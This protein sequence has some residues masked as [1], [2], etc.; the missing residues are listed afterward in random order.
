[1]KILKLNDDLDLE[2]PTELLEIETF[3]ILIKRPKIGR[4]DT[5][6]RKK[7]IA[8]KELAYVFHM[9][10]PNSK[11]YN[12]SE[13]ER[14][15]K[16]KQ[17]LFENIVE[18]E[19][20]AEVQACIDKYRELSKT[21]SLHAVDSMLNSLHECNDII[22]EITKQL[23]QDLKDGKHKSGINNKRGQ[24]V[25]GTELM[26]NDLTALLKV[27]KEIPNHIEVLER[28]QKKLQEESKTA[29]TKIK[30]R[31]TVSDRER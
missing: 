21:P 6:G 17:D 18:W 25:S 16:L 3:K 13:E 12:Y 5:D 23:K 30:G 11:Y 14:K 4:G 1:M 7:L 28:L 2:I 8:K 27:S 10:D 31:I 29:A 15:V 26:L 19:P 20:D 22:I 9:A 24:I